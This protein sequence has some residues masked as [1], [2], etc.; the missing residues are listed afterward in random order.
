MTIGLLFW[1]LMLIWLIFGLY[2]AWPTGGQPGWTWAPVGGSLILFILMLLLGWHSF[3][4]P[5]K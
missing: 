4:A 2:T 3:G 1:I 5:I